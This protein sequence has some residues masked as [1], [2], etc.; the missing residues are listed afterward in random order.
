MSGPLEGV[1]VLDFSDYVIGPFCT[2]VLGDMGADVMKV[3]VAPLSWTVA[4]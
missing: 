2:W 1:R 3:E 4:S